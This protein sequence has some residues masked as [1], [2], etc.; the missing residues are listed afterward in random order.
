MLRG[1]YATYTI[2]PGFEY[3]DVAYVSLESAFDGYSPEE[4]EARRRRLMADLEALPGVEA[5]ASADQEPLGDDTAPALIRL[6]GESERQS[7][8]GEV[9]TVSQDYFSVLELPI[10]RGRA[11]TE[12]EVSEPERPARVRPSSAK[13]RPATS[14][15]AATR[16]AGRCCGRDRHATSTPCRS[17]AW[18]RMR[19]SPRSDRSIPITCTCPA[20]GARCWSRAAPTRDDGVGHPRRR[21]SGRPDAR[22]HGAPVGGDARVVARYFRRR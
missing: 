2:D 15:R 14:G 8:V 13:R 10:V 6:P 3:R 19:R 18:P 12:D 5:V 21:E 22:R 9:I 11:F 17:S 16:S 1:L 20:R 4:S 7:R